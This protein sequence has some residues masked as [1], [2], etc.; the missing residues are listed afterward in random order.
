MCGRLWRP[1]LR[2]CRCAVPRDLLARSQRRRARHHASGRSRDPDA[3]RIRFRAE[4]RKRE[5]HLPANSASVKSKEVP[6]TP[7]I[8]PG[9]AALDEQRPKSPEWAV[10]VTRQ[11]VRLCYANLIAQAALLAVS[12]AALAYSRD[13]V[14]P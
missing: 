10:Q 6:P 2:D 9:K 14:P 11:N 8:D 12:L 3:A 7:V 13:F 4:R 1:V 5:L